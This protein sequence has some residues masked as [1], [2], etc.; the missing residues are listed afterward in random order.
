MSIGVPEDGRVPVCGDSNE[1]PRV[2]SVALAA[3]GTCMGR[4]SAPCCP[5]GNLLVARVDADESAVLGADVNLS[6]VNDRLRENGRFHF[7]LIFDRA[8]IRGYLHHL[9][10]TS[11]QQP[12]SASG[13]RRHG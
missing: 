13:D 8:R 3:G 6:V 2:S 5:A 10:V 1:L 12:L 7:V 9:S 11:R 4:V